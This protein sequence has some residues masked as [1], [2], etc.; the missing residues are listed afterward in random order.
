[1]HYPKL[2][3]GGDGS[4]AEIYEQWASAALSRPEEANDS[5]VAPSSQRQ[6][7]GIDA[8]AETA[9]TCT[10]QACSCQRIAQTPTAR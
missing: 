4:Y 6:L 10:R 9:N 1:M 7:C 2:G 5:S 3:S 8:V